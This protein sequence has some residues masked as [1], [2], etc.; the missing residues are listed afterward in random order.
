MKW[1][2]SDVVFDKVKRDWFLTDPTAR[3]IPRDEVND[4]IKCSI[5][6]FAVKK[7]DKKYGRL[8]SDFTMRAK[9]ACDGHGPNARIPEEWVTMKWLVNVK[10][11]VRAAA[12]ICAKNPHQDIY[13][14]TCDAKSYFLNYLI[15]A[16]C[17]SQMGVCYRNSE[18][19]RADPRGHP[20]AD[21][22]CAFASADL[23]LGFVAHRG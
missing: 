14:W 20:C 9:S 13:T 19:F 2:R 11:M 17:R 18:G 12:D 21:K 10:R 15:S 1:E 16:M 4:F 7:K 22:S 23:R 6:M 3:D 8:I 5:L